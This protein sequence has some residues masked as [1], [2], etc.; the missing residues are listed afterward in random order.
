[1]SVTSSRTPASRDYE[2]LKVSARRWKFIGLK[3]VRR[4]VND[5]GLLEAEAYEIA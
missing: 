4:R 3:S 2:N 1:V 5:R